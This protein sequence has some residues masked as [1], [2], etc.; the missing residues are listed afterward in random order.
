M[1]TKSLNP[2]T[3][4]L[5]T[6]PEAMIKD[7]HRD[8][9]HYVL[10]H[11]LHLQNVQTAIL[12]FLNNTEGLVK[13]TLLWQNES[14]S[15][16]EACSTKALPQKPVFKPLACCKFCPSFSCPPLPGPLFSCIKLWLPALPQLSPLSWLHPRL[17]SRCSAFP[18]PCYQLTSPD[19]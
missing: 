19:I 8:L 18:S 15:I 3:W 6:Y 10:Q 4:P 2:A 17:W 9:Q 12:R 11:Y 7:G 14:G 16:N 1:W 13:Q 5:R